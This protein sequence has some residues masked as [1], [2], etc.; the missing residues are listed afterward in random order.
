MR[1]TI[2]AAQKPLPLMGRGWGGVVSPVTH[3]TSLTFTPTQPS[4]IEGEGFRG[5]TS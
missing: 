4:P 5:L 2:T 3:R 1:A